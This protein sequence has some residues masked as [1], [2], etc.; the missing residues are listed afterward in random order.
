MTTLINLLPYILI[1][2]LV[3]AIIAFLASGYVKAPTDI[4]FI[5]SGL[6]D[7]P[8]VVIGK[9]SIKIPFL[10]RKDELL[11]QL[12]PVDIQTN[13]SI[14]TADYINIKVNSNA[15]IKIGKDEALMDKAQQ[16]FLGKDTKYIANVA[17]EVLEGNIREIIGKM[18]LVEMVGDR[19][20]FN[21][22]VRENA[23]PDLA[24]MGLEII[25]FNVQNFWDDNEVIKNLGIDNIVNIQKN[26]AISKATA[27]KEIAKA[28]AEAEREANDARVASQ[29]AIAEKNNELSIKKA[30]LKKV[31][32]SK[33]AEADAAYEIQQQ[34]QRKEIEAKTAEANIIKQEKAVL[35]KEKEAQV[36]ERELEATVKKQADAELYN[37]Q[38]LAE[39]DLFKRKKEA[40]AKR[41]EMEQAAEAEKYRIQKE[42]EAVE[43]KASAE[44]L[45]KEKEALGIQA[46]GKA[47]AQAIEAKLLAEAEGL[48]KKAEAMNKMQQAAVIEMV[49]DKL[50][51][52]YKNI[53]AP[54]ANVDKITMY[55]SG[56]EA[57]LV[58]S[59]MTSGNKI[60]EGLKDSIGLDLKSLVSGIIGG[61]LVSTPHIIESGVIEEKDLEGNNI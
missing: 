6:K 59:I 12:I 38:Q 29:Q 36:K 11:L 27:E 25:N 4:A 54:L 45:A 35:L 49:V 43:A 32:D 52:I 21:E 20:K 57:K 50:P 33:T 5:I 14:P 18:K 61:K 34:E 42:A 10:E 19:Q 3:I 56:N 40:E 13:N 28:Q 7:K 24:N 15:N 16:N 17:R 55:G 48:D 41:I 58:E 9:A 53:A 26:A 46:V 31:E 51:E 44:L 1:G 22:L 2:V 8:R 47:E 39:A 30:E 60:S 23:T 37:S